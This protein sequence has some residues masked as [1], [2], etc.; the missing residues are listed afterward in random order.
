M[1]PSRTLSNSERISQNSSTIPMPF[2]VS[3]TIGAASGAPII[4]AASGPSISVSAAFCSSHWATT[5]S[6]AVLNGNARLVAISPPHRK[7]AANSHPYSGSR[8]SRKRR[9]A[10]GTIASSDDQASAFRNTPVAADPRPPTAAQM[11]SAA[12]TSSTASTTVTV[13]ATRGRRNGEASGSVAE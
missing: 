5:T 9:I 4:S 6:N 13:R 3:S 2:V 8:R 11:I 10:T 1:N 12:S 7:A